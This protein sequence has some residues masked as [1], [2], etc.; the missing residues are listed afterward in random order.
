MKFSLLSTWD[1]V[2]ALWVRV[3]EVRCHGISSIFV[4]VL[5]CKL[6]HIPP[7]SQGLLWDGRFSESVMISMQSFSSSVIL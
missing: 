3:F 4:T 7:P 6:Y 1:V 5:V 2:F